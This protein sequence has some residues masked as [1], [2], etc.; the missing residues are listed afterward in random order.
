M[1]QMAGHLGNE[2]LVQLRP[3]P[4]GKPQKAD[5][6]RRWRPE[7]GVNERGTGSG[8]RARL[9]GGSD[10]F[11]AGRRVLERE[12]GAAATASHRSVEVADEQVAEFPGIAE[13][14]AMAARNLIGDDA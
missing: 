13:R 10:S 12:G 3:V 9:C 7:T 14:G 5:R 2:R 11:W 1:P 8:I 6:E 4:E